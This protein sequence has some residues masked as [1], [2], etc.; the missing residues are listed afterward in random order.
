VNFVMQ[1]K[2]WNTSHNV[3]KL[4]GSEDPQVGAV[5]CIGIPKDAPH[6]IAAGGAKGEVSVWDTRRTKGIGA[7]YS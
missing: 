1:I 6:L 5:L 2:L 7:F 4:L 3:P